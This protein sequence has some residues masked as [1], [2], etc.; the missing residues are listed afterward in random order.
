LGALGTKEKQKKLFGNCI[1]MIATKA[2]AQN[3]VFLSFGQSP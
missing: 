3:N 1:R 2:N